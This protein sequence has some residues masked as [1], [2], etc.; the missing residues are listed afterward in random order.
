MEPFTPDPLLYGD[1]LPAFAPADAVA[2]AVLVLAILLG[3]LAWLLRGRRPPARP[4]LS[5]RLRFPSNASFPVEAAAAWLSA[6]RPLLAAETEVVALEISSAEEGI[7]WHLAVSEG[8]VDALRGQLAAWFPDARLERQPARR[9]SGTSAEVP[10]LPAKADLWPLRIPTA[11]EPDPILGVL[12]GL[13]GSSVAGVRLLV[14]PP[15]DDWASWAPAALSAIQEGRPLPPRGALFRLWQTYRLFQAGPA[16]RGGRPLLRPEVGRELARKAQGPVLSVRIAAWAAGS[17]SEAALSRARELAGQVAAASAHPAGNSLLP[18]RGRLLASPAGVG[19]SAPCAVLSGAEIA[20]L[21]HVPNSAHPLVTS[22]SSRRVP[23]PPEL[24]RPR[25]ADAGPETVLGEA[26]APEGPVPFGLAAAERRQHLYVVGKTGTGKST[27]LAGI[28]RQDL[29][30]GR[31]LAL[32]DPHGDLALR[33]LSLVPPER[34]PDVVYLDPA[35]PDA[36]VPLNPLAHGDPSLR[37][38][39]ASGVIGAFRKLFADSWGPRLEHLLRH[40]LLLLLETPDPSLAQLPLLLTDRAYRRSLVGFARDPVVRGFFEGEFEAY[41]GR[42][43]SEAV[44]PVLNKLGAALASPTVRHVVGGRAPGL[45]LR[46]LM[47]RRG[48]LVA[49]LSMGRIGED[50][51]ALLGGLL[52]A[53]LQLAAMSRADVAEEDRPDF[54]LLADEFQHVAGD[55]FLGILSE[56]RKYRL[57]LVIAHQYLDQ[58]PEPVSRAVF[59]NVGAL[60]VF[61]AGHADASRLARELSPAFAA[62][63]LVALPGY[64]FCARLHR[65]GVTL[66]AFS[67]RTILLPGGGSAPAELTEMAR[68]RWSR[69]RAAVESEIADLWEGRALDCC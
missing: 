40:A 48:V 7:A 44:A 61:R 20:S 58:V 54:A 49:N 50:S 25:P 51:S 15:P 14:G 60:A 66:P 21:F 16:P 68:E 52:V 35:D 19:E 9:L 55:A 27:L 63:D 33:V 34:Y 38:L 69:P 4:L 29:E 6:L 30:A 46:S 8:R 59:G 11:R 23:P 31:G 2:V 45:D 56:A 47:D 57:S 67:A 12:A 37:P 62:E 64:R 53:G 3:A 36:V 17:S 41:E 24:L 65:D 42:F 28:A 26:L 43:R 18:G 5:W 1:G 32:L 13:S 10:L 39:V 22:E